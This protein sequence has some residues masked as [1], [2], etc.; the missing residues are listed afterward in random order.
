MRRAWPAAGRE[1]RA[2]A[3]ISKARSEGGD[4]RTREAPEGPPVG[5]DSRGAGRGGGDGDGGTGG[6]VVS[7]G[8]NGKDIFGPYSKSNSFRGVQICSHLSPD[9]QHSIPYPYPNTQITYL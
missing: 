8:Q 2:G 1:A 7:R 9:I 3:A 4:S 5:A 6:R